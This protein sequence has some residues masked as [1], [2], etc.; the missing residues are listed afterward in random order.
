MNLETF[1]MLNLLTSRRSFNHSQGERQARTETCH[2][3]TE[4]A[5]IKANTEKTKREREERRQIS[6]FKRKYKRAS[7]C[8]LYGGAD[9]GEIV[10]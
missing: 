2:F 8:V 1:S 4:R 7:H 5:I 9:H 3:L 6:L 10:S